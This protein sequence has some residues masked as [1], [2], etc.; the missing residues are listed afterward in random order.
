MIRT[1]DTDVLVLAVA[2]VQQLPIEELW[3]AFDSG[4]TFRYIPAHDIAH[5]L[6]PEKCIA[7]PFLHAFSGC[8][9]VSCFAGHGKKSVW[10]IWNI[11]DEVTPAFCTLASN[12][13]ASCVDDHLEVIER[14]VVL[15]YN[16]ASSDMKGE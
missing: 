1:V 4:K 15:L 14:F 6:G 2:A 13:E 12:P 3:L 10:E 8:D 7:L 5:G 16:R 9:T 11:F